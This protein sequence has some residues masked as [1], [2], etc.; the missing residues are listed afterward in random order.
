MPRRDGTGPM[1][2]G[3]MTGRGLGN[4]VGMR[5]YYGAGYGAGFAGYGRGCGLGYRRGGRFGFG[6]GQGRYVHAPYQGYVAGNP[7]DFSDDIRQE[8]VELERRLAW[9]NQQLETNKKNEG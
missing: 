4:C 2:Q 5:P 9:I 3:S 8:K 6:L 1:G 7:V